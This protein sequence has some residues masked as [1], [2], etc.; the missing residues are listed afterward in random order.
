VREQVAAVSVGIVEGAPLLDLEAS[1]DQAAEVD[2]NVVATAGGTLVE[3]QGTGEKRSFTRDEL[4]ALLDL[5]FGGIHELV[6]RQ[7][8]ALAELMEEVA[9]VGQRGRRRAVPPKDER[10]LYG[11]PR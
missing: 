5:A 8:D 10:D 3:L 7:S 6:R 9:T 4:D 1:E 2:L 11:R